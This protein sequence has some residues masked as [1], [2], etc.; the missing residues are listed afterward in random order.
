MLVGVLLLLMLGAYFVLRFGH[1]TIA[2][3]E[4]GFERAIFITTNAATLTGFHLTVNTGDYKPLGQATI[5]TLIVAGSLVS[6]LVGGWALVRLLKFN[7]TDWQ[8]TQATFIIYVLAMVIGANLFLDP[9]G[10]NLAAFFNSASAFGNAGHW[11]GSMPE[12]D[13]LRTHIVVLPFAFLGGLSIPV[14]LD[15]I[16]SLLL[17][18]RMHPHTFAVMLMSL[19]LYLVG[20]GL[21][22]ILEIYQGTEAR[23]AVTLGTTEALNSRSL[24]MPLNAFTMLSR[25]SQWVVLLLMLIG[26]GSASTS[27]GLKCTTPYVLIRDSIR[28]LRGREMTRAL[29]IAALWMLVYLLV[30]FG[31]TV[32]LIL[33]YPQVQSDR[34]LFLAVSAVGNVGTSQ[35]QITMIGS[36]LYILTFAMLFG[37]FA[38]LALLW[39]AANKIPGKV[40]V[41]VG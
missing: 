20:M 29:A 18:R 10:G 41:A 33:N 31:T 17:A 11:I 28:L 26:A 16:S 25:P 8:I 38:P 24:G 3:N 30:I 4:I 6:L 19:L 13:S 2:G 35:E 39:W 23:M 14:L 40:D 34:L 22:V 1:A 36:G 15:F 7:Y 32:L 9:E 12:F 37:R 5:L 27:G 21:I